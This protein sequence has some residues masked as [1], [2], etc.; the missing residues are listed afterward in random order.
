MGNETARE[1]LEDKRGLSLDTIKRYGIGW[2]GNRYM[3]PIRDEKGELVNVRMYSPNAEA[4]WIHWAGHGS[5]PRLYPLDVL[6]ADPDQVTICEGELDTLLALQNGVT[7][8]TSTGG[9]KSM[10]RWRIEHNKW[11]RDKE[12]RICFDCDAEGRQ[13]TRKAADKLKDVAKKIGIIEL[14]FPLGTHKDL[15]DYF[16]EGG[17]RDGLAELVRSSTTRPKN[18]VT[19]REVSYDALRR[20]KMEGRP[21]VIEGTIAGINQSQLLLPRSLQGKCNYD[22]DPKKCSGCPLN[23]AGGNLKKNVEGDVKLRLE[24]LIT[25]TGAGRDTLYKKAMDLPKN[26]PKVE[27]KADDNSY[28]DCEIRNGSNVSEEAYPLLLRHD[29][30]PPLLNSLYKYSGR[31]QNSPR[32]QRALFVADACTPA[33]QDLDSFIPDPLMM[34]RAEEWVN[35]FRGDPVAQMDQIAELLEL[36]VTRI[37]GQRML[38]IGID[39]VYHSVLNFRFG[40]EEPARGWM[41]VLAV[42]DTRSGKSTA[43][44]K[45]N[46]LYGRGHYEAVENASIAGLLYGVEKRA[47]LVGGAWQASVGVLPLNDRGL[48]TLDEAQG[49]A[50]EQIGQMSSMRSDGEVQVTK[51]RQ[52]KVPARVR[53]IWL[54]NGR[55][56]RYA[57]GMDFLQDL[58]GQPED[59]ARVDIPLY[60]SADIGDEIEKRRNRYGKL[61]PDVQ[62]VMRWIVLWAWSRTKEQVRWS[63]TAIDALFDLSDNLAEQ[64]ATRDLPVFAANEAH[65][66]LA[67]MSV[68]LAARL[69]STPNGSAVSVQ[70]KHVLAA[71]RLYERFLGAPELELADVKHHE[72]AEKEAGDTNSDELLEHLNRLPRE[73]TYKLTQGE[74]RS[75]GAVDYNSMVSSSLASIDAIKPHGEGYIVPRWAQLIAKEVLK[76]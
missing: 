68:A 75:L 35:G 17:T 76:R 38:H 12:V 70:A 53:L 24:L 64:Y 47:S 19:Y 41:E 37:F 14:P 60:I 50:K 40:D 18:K 55:K 61:D 43:A 6:I 39:L 59:L 33:R 27:I 63:K 34:R 3:F 25:N 73:V 8:I 65:I 36:H 11:L 54:A 28:W 4:K 49:L 5:P 69:Y 74:F 21:V 58:M 71:E 1:Y 66:R 20:G 62:E 10:G 31:L 13:A 7:A 67:R 42:G 22:W 2:N 45:I 52:G 51:I 9:V 57:T 23:E 16:L 30:N 56:P 46:Q 15:T 72:E 44:K 26:C 48:V 32:G 29:G